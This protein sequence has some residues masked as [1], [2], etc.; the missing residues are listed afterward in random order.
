ME[1]L[2]R[3]TGRPGMCFFI[4]SC[5]PA[6]SPIDVGARQQSDPFQSPKSAPSDLC[7]EACPQDS[8]K[9][10]FSGVCG[11]IGKVHKINS[12]PASLSHPPIAP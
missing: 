11:R 1:P 12:S 8:E 4:F 10:D 9:S 6:L 2:G 5:D 3:V 7:K